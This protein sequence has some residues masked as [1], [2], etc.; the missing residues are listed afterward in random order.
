MIGAFVSSA[1]TLALVWTSGLSFGAGTPFV[2][3]VL[4][5]FAALSFI[6]TACCLNVFLNHP[7]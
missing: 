2:S 5:L 3:F 7:R 6:V 4:G 1:L